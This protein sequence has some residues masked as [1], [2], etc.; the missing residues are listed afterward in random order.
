MKVHVI[1]VV[2]RDDGVTLQR[3]VSTETQRYWNN[4]N[5][6]FQ[7]ETKPMLRQ[8]LDRLI[9]SAVNQTVGR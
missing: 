5:K 2:E 4:P 1:I 8:R 3:N 6:T 7:N 9:V